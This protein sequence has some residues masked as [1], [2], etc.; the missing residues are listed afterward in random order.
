MKDIIN[1][2]DKDGFGQHE[3]DR[4]INIVERLGID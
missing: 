2:I 1:R 4:M 3:M